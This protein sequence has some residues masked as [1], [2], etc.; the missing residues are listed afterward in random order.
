MKAMVED[1]EETID[2][3]ESLADDDDKPK[4]KQFA[5]NT[6][7]TVRQHQERAKSIQEQ[8]DRQGETPRRNP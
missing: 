2:R 7:Q 3:L 1:H 8:L 5:S 4:L 6:L